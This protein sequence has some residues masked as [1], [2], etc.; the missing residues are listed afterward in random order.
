MNEPFHPDLFPY[1][2]HDVFLEDIE[3]AKRVPDDK[4][5]VGW[6]AE[7]LVWERVFGPGLPEEGIDF[8]SIQ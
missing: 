1:A 2:H 8:N 4:P 6:R 3:G 5:L 7:P